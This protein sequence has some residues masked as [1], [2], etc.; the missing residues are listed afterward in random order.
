MSHSVP[1]DVCVCLSWYRDHSDIT[2]YL[3]FPLGICEWLWCSR[4]MCRA[5]SVAYAHPWSGLYTPKWL[6]CPLKS[7]VLVHS[8]QAR[9]HDLFG[10]FL[11]IFSGKETKRANSYP[12]SLCVL[13]KSFFKKAYR[14]MCSLLR[15]PYVSLWFKW[16]FVEVKTASAEKHK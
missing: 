16:G 2:Y 7:Q 4:K 10:S 1:L 15:F 12:W 6:R 5:H 14:P 3:T 13:S 8:C 9:E 11:S